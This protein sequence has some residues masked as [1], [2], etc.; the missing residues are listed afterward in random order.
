VIIELTFEWINWPG[1]AI[2][3]L[4]VPGAG[5][6]AERDCHTHDPII[7]VWGDGVYWGNRGIAKGAPVFGGLAIALA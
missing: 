5:L 3:G 1:H 6:A 7:G 2:A 4:R